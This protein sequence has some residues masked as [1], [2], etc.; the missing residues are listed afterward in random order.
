MRAIRTHLAL[1]DMRDLAAEGL[2]ISTG[3]KDA[4]VL[5]LA[6]IEDEVAHVA[7]SFILAVLADPVD[8]VKI[9]DCLR[10]LRYARTRFHDYGE[11]HKTSLEDAMVLREEIRTKIKQLEGGPN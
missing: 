8:T 10:K 3:K 11:F 5:F 7:Y 9:E 2:N 4:D 1:R 6:E